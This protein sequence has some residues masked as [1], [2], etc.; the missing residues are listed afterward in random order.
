MPDHTRLGN[1]DTRSSRNIQVSGHRSHSYYMYSVLHLFKTYIYIY[2]ESYRLV[3]AYMY[4]IRVCVSCWQSSY[5][6][7]IVIFSYSSSRTKLT[8]H[9]HTFT[10]CKYEYEDYSMVCNA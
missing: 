4:N 3:C 6:R 9:I 2:K 7:N 5:H 10:Q 8:E 1:I